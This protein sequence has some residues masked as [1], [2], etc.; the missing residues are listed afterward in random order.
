M[1]SNPDV[2]T[3][4]TCCHWCESRSNATWQCQWFG[5]EGSQ[6]SLQQIP[7]ISSH[8]FVITAVISATVITSTEKQKQIFAPTVKMH[9]PIVQMCD[10]C[11]IL[12]SSTWAETVEA[13]TTI[14]ILPLVE[15]ME[16]TSSDLDRCWKAGFVTFGEQLFVCFCASKVLK[17]SM[18]LWIK[19]ALVIS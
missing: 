12:C 1:L 4:Q 15:T 9:L 5:K 17:R 3:Y 7:I 14:L 13:K 2:H 16:Q 18:L 8:R 11:H 10:G 19:L 6:L